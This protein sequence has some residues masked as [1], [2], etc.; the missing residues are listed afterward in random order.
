MIDNDNFLVY[1]KKLNL[2]FIIYNFT[3]TINFILSEYFELSNLN[4]IYLLLLKEPILFLYKVKLFSEN[5]LF[6]FFPVL[7]KSRPPVI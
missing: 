5:E 1:I 2:N 4:I 6:L 3:P 7:F